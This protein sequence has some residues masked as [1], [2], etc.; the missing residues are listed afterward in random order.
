MSLY[1]CYPWFFKNIYTQRRRD[2]WVLEK[3]AY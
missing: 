3:L 2:I 1:I